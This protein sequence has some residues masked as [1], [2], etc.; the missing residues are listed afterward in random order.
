MAGRPLCQ[1]LQEMLKAE[2][3]TTMTAMLTGLQKKSFESEG[4]EADL[5]FHMLEG[6][7]PPL[8]G[9]SGARQSPMLHWIPQTSI[10]S[11]QLFERAMEKAGQNEDADNEKGP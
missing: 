6:Q 5:R 7:P 11:Q 3:V 10:G 4:V 8:S 2:K 1:H 9:I